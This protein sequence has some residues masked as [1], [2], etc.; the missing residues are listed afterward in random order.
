MTQDDLR[1]DPEAH[2]LTT[3]S[4]IWCFRE[5]NSPDPEW[6]AFD[7]RNQKLLT[8]HMEKVASS[9]AGTI[10]DEVKFNDSHIF[11][12]RKKV[13]IFP[14]KKCGCYTGNTRDETIVLQVEYLEVSDDTTFVY[15]NKEAK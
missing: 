2:T 5:L 1:H 10:D 8:A 4:K 11:D 7:I 15:K 13:R 12:K 6:T 14:D 9:K 3:L